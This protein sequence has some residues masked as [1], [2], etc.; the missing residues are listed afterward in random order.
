MTTLSKTNNYR[1]SIPKSF[2]VHVKHCFV[3]YIIF[4]IVSPVSLFAQ[5]DGDAVLNRQRAIFLLNIASQLKSANFN[6]ISTYK[7]A[8]LGSA[9]FATSLTE[10]SKNRTV[11]SKRVTISKHQSIANIDGFQLVYVN[12]KDG[13]KLKDILNKITGKNTLLVSESYG[14]NLSMV[15]I[16]LDGQSIEFELNDSRL[17]QEG[18]LTPSALKQHAISSSDHWQELYLDAEKKLKQ[19]RQKIDQ[20][21]KLLQEQQKNLTNLENLTEGQKDQLLQ[22]TQ[23][24]ANRTDSIVS[25]QSSYSEKMVEL[26]SLEDKINN[27]EKLMISQRL[28]LKQQKLEVSQMDNILLSKTEQIETQKNQLT[29]R[30]E[31][32][33]LQRNYNL[34]MIALVIIVFASSFFIFWGYVKNIRANRKLV[35]LNEKKN[36]L[37][38]VVAHDLRSPINQV[39]GLANLILLSET[40]LEDTSKEYVENIVQS[41][42]RLNE[43]IRRILDINA[44][45]SN[46]INIELEQVNLNQLMSQIATNF[47]V[48]ADEKSIEL[49]QE[50][51]EKDVFANADRNYL[52]QVLENIISNAIKFSESDKKIQLKVSHE[53]S[54]AIMSVKDE[55]PG[56]SKEDQ[57][58]LFGSY[59]KLTA[60]PTAG[61]DSSGLGLSIAKK[62]IEAM[63]GSITC[64]SQLNRGTT[65]RLRFSRA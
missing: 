24:I 21:K 10:V 11:L 42:D 12:K 15:N 57:E 48:L 38:G 13:Y 39:K 36:E 25:L 9:S 7:I 44:I 46:K 50:Y 5:N 35:T 54:K 4:F 16:I 59:E 1:P 52:L 65:F 60:Q 29:D 45:E 49:Q 26:K 37:I 3:A 51:P 32:L 18:F 56:I 63:K 23:E 19:E 30:D 14:F 62:Y 28:H 8:V 22:Q 34:L 27:Q 33:K 2:I 31:Q 6:N 43:M 61:E 20:Q 58:R 53:K 41:C 40:K 55:G 17:K 64:D 47:K